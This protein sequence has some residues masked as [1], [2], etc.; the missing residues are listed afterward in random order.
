MALKIKIKPTTAKQRSGKQGSLFLAPPPSPPAKVATTVVAA[1][2]P[3]PGVVVA[4]ASTETDFLDFAPNGTPFDDDFA[5]GNPVTVA[6][7]DPFAAL[8]MRNN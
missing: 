1:P 2:T 8:A 4:A 5:A 3:D 7:N 6:D